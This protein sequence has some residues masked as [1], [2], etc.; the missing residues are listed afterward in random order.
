MG[1]SWKTKYGP[2]RVRQDPPTLKE[3]IVAAQ[4]L[5]DKLQDQVEI[6]ASLMNLS[7]DEVRSEV[8]KASPDKSASRITLSTGRERTSRTVIVERRTSRRIGAMSA[9]G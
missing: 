3:A 5:S 4:G 1:E 2:R 6:A 9:R 7:P 8:M